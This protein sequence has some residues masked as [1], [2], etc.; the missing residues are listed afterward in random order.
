MHIGNWYDDRSHRGDL[1][2][3][4]D[5]ENDDVADPFDLGA[6]G[7]GRPDVPYGR[8]VTPPG[9]PGP[10]EVTRSAAGPG[11]G[12][13]AD[14]DEF[15]TMLMAA[16]A[17]SFAACCRLIE[18]LGLPTPTRGQVR[19]ARRRA[20][21]RRAEQAAADQ[22]QR[23]PR[24]PAQVYRRVNRQTGSAAYLPPP[25][26]PAARCNCCELVIGPFGQCGCH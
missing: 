19:Q 10:R 17:L 21:A 9:V 26:A 6:L 1:D 22:R 23:A 4:R 24:A 3:R 7:T 18:A 12:G 14:N 15:I 2:P 20:E 25:A 16:P 8:R 13:P 11:A 5:H